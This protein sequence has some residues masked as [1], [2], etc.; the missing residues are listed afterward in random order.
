[1]G[2]REGRKGGYL[3]VDRETATGLHGADQLPGIF[4]NEGVRREGGRAGGS[5][6]RR[7]GKKD[8][9]TFLGEIAEGERK[10]STRLGG[11]KLALVGEATAGGR[12]FKFK[13]EGGSG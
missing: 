3:V 8:A 10:S 4:G 12:A 9:P 11:P 2:G 13:F 6:G 1:V 5:T 7:R